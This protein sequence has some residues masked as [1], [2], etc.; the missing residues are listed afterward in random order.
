VTER[1]A[2]LVDVY[3]TLLSCDFEGHRAELPA[4]AGLSAEAWAHGVRQIG[5]ATGTGQL[6]TAQAYE[7]VLYA[8]GAEAR[9]DLVRALVDLDRELLLRHARLYDDA[10]PFLQQLRS[11]G[12]KI[13]IV[14]NCSEHTRD[15]LESNGVAALADAMALS[16]EVGAFKP[17][18][19]IY[20]CALDQ[21]G[22]PARRAVFVDDQPSFC[23]AAAALGITAV[24]IVRGELDG[25]VPAPGTTLVRSLR[26][27]E[28][29]F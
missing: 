10:I 5:S 1:E 20:T 3:Q 29:M 14:S 6:S 9:P 24:Q 15:L 25:K 13:A 27:V 7:R 2:C 17:A 16:C 26:E 4:L 21:L 19:E 18:A 28:A 22:V 11:R 12:T 23:A 8:G